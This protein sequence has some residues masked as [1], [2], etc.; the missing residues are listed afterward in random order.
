MKTK[1]LLLL[2]FKINLLTALGQLLTSYAG[3]NQ[4]FEY[5]TSVVATYDGGYAIC[6]YS[7]SAFKTNS[8]LYKYDNN[9]V[10]SWTKIFNSTYSNA[11]TS[12]VQ[13]DDS[14]LVIVG[15]ANTGTALANFEIFIAKVRLN[16]TVLFHKII[17]NNSSDDAVYAA[18]RSPDGGIILAVQTN[19]NPG[20]A[21]DL[22]L[23]KISASGNILWAKDLIDTYFAELPAALK[24]DAYGNILMCGSMRPAITSNPMFYDIFLIKC[25]STGNLNWAKRLGGTNYDWANGLTIL[26]NDSGYAICGRTESYGSG[27]GITAAYLFLLD[28]AGLE[29]WS[30]TFSLTSFS[31]IEYYGV[32]A[33]TLNNIYAA[34]F[35]QGF[36]SNDPT[37][38]VK[39]DQN[40]NN[41]WQK[42]YDDSLNRN[43]SFSSMIYLPNASSSFS[44]LVLCGQSDRFN[45]TKGI[46]LRIT[47]TNGQACDSNG[48]LTSIAID[49]GLTVDPWIL[50]DTIN[51]A[52][53]DHGTYA[54][55]HSSG[56]T[57]SLCNTIT[58]SPEQEFSSK[59]ELFPNPANNNVEIRFPK[60]LNSVANL[61]LYNCFGQKVYTGNIEENQTNKVINLT[62]LASGM[63]FAQV[64][65]SSGLRLTRNLIIN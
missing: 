16:G 1:I 65:T 14:C 3:I 62:N 23:M 31:L 50:T 60:K 48:I 11:A 38:L 32:A 58:G 28:T 17:G 20:S 35:I 26:N 25:D 36:N 42:L 41:L 33:D 52:M 13:T 29:K 9:G 47:D 4:S 40:G 64:T 43:S 63:Y 21:I 51:T 15:Y 6:G 54:L 45:F 7:D 37:L 2:L 22:M 30:R 59:F 8:L 5:S 44:Q 55:Y 49:S 61:C 10:L 57:Y 46:E 27:G 24:C 19:K 34:G 53:S 18:D 12:V 39:Y 56:T